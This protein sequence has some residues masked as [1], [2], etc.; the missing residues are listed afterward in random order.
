MNVLP[1]GGHGIDHP[2]IFLKLLIL[3][4]KISYPYSLTDADLQNDLKKFFKDNESKEPGS[5]MPGYD[6]I[7]LH[8]WHIYTGGLR[9]VNDGI[10]VASNI[11]LARNLAE[12][13]LDSYVED[14]K[15]PDFG[16]GVL[17][18]V[19]VNVHF[20]KYSEETGNSK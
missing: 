11:D 2:L 14:Q 20:L 4:G 13:A 10:W 8:M 15:D 9:E 1:Y 6:S 18:G 12:N 17:A 16:K 5:D 7:P 19:L 3:L